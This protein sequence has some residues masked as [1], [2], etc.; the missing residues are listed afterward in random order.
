M[1]KLTMAFAVILKALVT[2]EMWVFVK[3]KGKILLSRHFQVLEIAI[4]IVGLL[5]ETIVPQSPSTVV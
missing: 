2:V 3:H 5:M 1:V 4:Q